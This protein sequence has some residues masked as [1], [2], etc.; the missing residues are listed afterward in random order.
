MTVARGS[1][2]AAPLP[3]GWSRWWGEQLYN[4]ST[5][6]FCVSCEGCCAAWSGTVD[7]WLRAREE[8]GIPPRSEAQQL[9]LVAYLSGNSRLA[10]HTGEAVADDASLGGVLQRFKGTCAASLHGVALVYVRVYKGGTQNVCANL[11]RLDDASVAP[12]LLRAVESGEQPQGA[13]AVRFTFVR[14][15]LSHF[16]SGYSEISFRGHKPR[17]GLS[18]PERQYV[19]ALQAHPDLYSFM[20]FDPTTV[21][22]AHAF[23]RD[24]VGGHLGRM[25]GQ[26]RGR[27]KHLGKE[28]AQHH[29]QW[30]RTS[31]NTG[32]C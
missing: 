23:V 8:L 24:F 15:P 1:L 21:D 32:K 29:Y 5:Q 28:Q 10:R 20:R 3:R 14:E 13:R 18:R 19:D 2:D 9:A 26:G 22:A 12:S 4:T 11:A 7:Q 27:I 16:E 31:S 25:L 6:A 30:T 17:L